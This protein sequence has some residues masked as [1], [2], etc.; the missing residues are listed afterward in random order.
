[1]RELGSGVPACGAGGGPVPPIHLREAPQAFTWLCAL[2][3]GLDTGAEAAAGPVLWEGG[4]C[5]SRAAHEDASCLSWGFLAETSTPDTLYLWEKVGDSM[6]GALRELGVTRT[7]QSGRASCRQC[8]GH[9]G[10]RGR[11]QGREEP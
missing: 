3:A 2:V 11:V 4:L 1:M 6:T 7:V 8:S 10:L 5:P 9:H